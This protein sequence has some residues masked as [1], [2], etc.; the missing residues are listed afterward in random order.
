MCFLNFPAQT[1]GLGTNV[2]RCKECETGF[3]SGRNRHKQP[4]QN[5]SETV[6][7]GG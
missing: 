5:L 1:V 3:G 2:Q 4:D 7:E 6:R